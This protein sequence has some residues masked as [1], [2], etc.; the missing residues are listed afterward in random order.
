MVDQLLYQASCK[1]PT[2]SCGYDSLLIICRFTAEFNKLAD[3]HWPKNIVIVTH[4]YG[5]CQAVAMTK[6]QRYF[7]DI[8]VNYCGF[9]EMSRASRGSSVWKSEDEAN[10]ESEY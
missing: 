9:V 8:W 1:P 5:V 2:L 6:G 7:K 4:G 3:E 10:I